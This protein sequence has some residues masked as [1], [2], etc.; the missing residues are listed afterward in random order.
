M[1][2]RAPACSAEAAEAKE[3]GNRAFSAQRYEEAYQHFSEAI[4]RDPRSAL[5]R[6]NR[7]GALA[8]LGRHPEAL[9]DADLCVSLQPDWWKGY[10]R[11]GHAQFQLERYADSEAS[12]LQALQL[13]PQE[14]AIIVGLE[15]ARQMLRQGGLTHQP[16]LDPSPGLRSAAADAP[17]AP[18]LVSLYGADAPAVAGLSAVEGQF[19]RLNADEI[20]ARLEKGVGQL[21]DQAL[22]NELREAGVAVPASATRVDK[23]HLYLE[24]AR[25]AAAAQAAP[26]TTKQLAPSKGDRLIEQRKKWLGEWQAW[27]NERLIKE[28]RRLGV[29]GEGLSRGD[30]IDVLLKEKSDRFSRQGCTHR[31]M[32]ACGLAAVALTVLGTFGAMA[33]VI[34]GG[35]M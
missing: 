32:Q 11:R 23:V 22:D 20:R 13:N 10:T 8:C 35:D 12:Y 18:E 24:I 3:A 9:A 33:L 31:N 27:D 17:G 30:L 7:S 1:V 19:K 6:S 29:D 4:L 15:K 21:S 5:L 14:K 34:I 28:L 16:S 26:E 25:R 2:S